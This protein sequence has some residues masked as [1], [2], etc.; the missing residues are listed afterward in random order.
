MKPTD[1]SKIKKG[2]LI[3]VEWADSPYC[4]LGEVVAIADNC[5]YMCDGGD[6]WIFVIFD[7]DNVL[8]IEQGYFL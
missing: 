4:N 2:D 3:Y 7:V 6:V 8:L 1:Y 5:C